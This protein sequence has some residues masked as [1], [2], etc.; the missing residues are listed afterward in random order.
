[1]FLKIQRNSSIPMTKQIYDQVKHL[2]LSGDL[3]DDACLPSSRKLS[4]TLKVSRNV[5]VEVYEMLTAEGYTKSV[6]GSGVYVSKSISISRPEA[7]GPI[8]KLPRIEDTDNLI[9]FKVGNTA[10][11]KFPRNKWLQCYREGLSDL[12]DKE[13]GYGPSNGYLPFRKTLKDYLLRSRGI[14]C[15]EDQIIITS[16]TTQSLHL[17]TKYFSQLPGSIL[18]EEPTANTIRE[19]LEIS[20]PNTAYHP[21]DQ[22]GIDPDTLPVDSNLSCIL[23]TPSHQYPLGGS[24][25]ISRRVELI[26]YARRHK[27]YII[28]DDYDSEYR[29][30][31]APVESLYELDPEHVIY[32]SSFSKILMPGIR[33]GY[34]V[35]PNNLIENLCHLKDILD[36]Q[37]PIFIQ[38][39]MT[40]FIR[41]GYLEQHL[42]K[43]RKNY[44]RRRLILIH[45]LNKR[46]GDKVNILGSQTGIHLVAEFHNI[47]FTKELMDKIKKS[48]VYIAG[49][50]EHA[51][52]PENYRSQLLFGYGNIGEEEIEKGIEILHNCLKNEFIF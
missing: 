15:H 25:T 47:N 8:L 1:M 48:G 32:V 17:L 34:M 9:S 20:H 41:K 39:A 26:R 42:V 30:D 40:N 35:L 37:C 28:E 22:E 16:G 31:N 49:V 43:T 29:Y 21:V 27:C 45:A 5:V 38:A 46:F 13:L 18:F 24:L 44:R 50:S 36:V 12:P 10:L 51:A 14:N 23:A 33:I 19:L 6:R 3:K 4:E 2:I 52:I 7:K 11:D